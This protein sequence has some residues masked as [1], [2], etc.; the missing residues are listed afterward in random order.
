MKFSPNADVAMN[1]FSATDDAKSYGESDSVRFVSKSIVN[2]FKI[3]I[4]HFG[5]DP[6]KMFSN[7]CIFYMDVIQKS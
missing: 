2:F 6:K 4:F 3:V 7:R 5:F 1:A